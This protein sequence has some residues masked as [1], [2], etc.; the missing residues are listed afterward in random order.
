MDRNADRRFNWTARKCKYDV[1]DPFQRLYIL[2]GDTCQRMC[3][4]AYCY[5]WLGTDKPTAVQF[6]TSLLS[7]VW[8]NE[9]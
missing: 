1:T 5:I 6:C 2:L 7:F 9:R 8:S 4:I 3:V